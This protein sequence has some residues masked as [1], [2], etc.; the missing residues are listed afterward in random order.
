MKKARTDGPMDRGTKEPRDAGAP[1]LGSETR[2]SKNFD[3]VGFVLAGGQSSR[4]GTDKALVEFGGRPLIE[5]AIG[6]LKGAGLRVHIAGAGDSVRARLEANTAI[7]PDAETGRGPLSGVC[8]A[9]RSSI[10]RYAVFLPVDVPLIPTSLIFY[11]L[12]HA[13]TAASPVTVASVNASPQ[14][15]PA[16]IDREALAVLE[17]K[18]RSGELGCLAAFEAAAVQLR[19]PIAVLPVEVLVQSGQ[20]AH[21]EAI[22]AMRWFLNVNTAQDLCLASLVLTSRVS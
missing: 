21:P 1:G 16:I 14:T 10:A 22:P 2:E 4:M 7:I 18:L 11:L 15:F 6:I 12:R 19:R 5:H 8:A 20:V 3:A 17:E 9:L 13:R